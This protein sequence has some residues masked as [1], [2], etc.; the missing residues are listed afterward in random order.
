MAVK[1]GIIWSGCETSDQQCYGSPGQPQGADDGYQLSTNDQRVS[2]NITDFTAYTY[3]LLM[4]VSRE[5]R[6]SA[7][8]SR[9]CRPSVSPS[10]PSQGLDELFMA[11]DLGGL[12]RLCGSR[13]VQDLRG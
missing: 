7:Q 11:S 5:K 8:A 12:R 13:A 6:R 4:S 9:R 2:R 10:T 3:V 1:V